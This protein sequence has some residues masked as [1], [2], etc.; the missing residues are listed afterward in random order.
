VL[1]DSTRHANDA[2]IFPDLNPE[3]DLPAVSVPSGVRGEREK[4][5][6][7]LREAVEVFV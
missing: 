6:A 5:H 7:Q 2:L 4:H 3:L 1:E